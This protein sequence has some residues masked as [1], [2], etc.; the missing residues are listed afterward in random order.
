M[1]GVAGVTAIEVSV[2]GVTVSVAMPLMA[3][4]V[5]E[6]TV[7][8]TATVVA[9]PF[10]PAAFEIVAVAA[11]ADAHVVVLVST[12]VE[13]SVYVPVATNCGFEPLATVSE[14]AV[15]TAI[16]ASVWTVTVSVTMP[17]IAP[18]DAEMTL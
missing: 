4:V 10:E 9:R 2:A 11:V 5:A 8:P 7:V 18:M 17:L 12:C 15:V 6:M 3:P 14:P 13:P 16:E 1:D